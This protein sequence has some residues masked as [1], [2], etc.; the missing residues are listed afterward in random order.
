LVEGLA[1]ANDHD[2]YPFQIAKHVA[3]RDP[4][5]PIALVYEPCAAGFVARGIGAA[6]MRFAIHLD[7]KF[8]T[9]ADE[10]EDEWPSWMLSPKFVSRRPLA[11]FA[12]QQH[13][14]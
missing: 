7:G 8:R 1:R 10:I 9:H 3:R 11:Q 5:S 13:F 6:I 2:N 12:P 4:Q 14:R